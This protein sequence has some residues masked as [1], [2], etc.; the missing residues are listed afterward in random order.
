MTWI[1]E[2]HSKQS[3]SNFPARLQKHVPME[4][5]EHSKKDSYLYD[6]NS[7]IEEIIVCEQDESSE[8]NFISLNSQ[9]SNKMLEL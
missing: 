6:S 4:S 2:A 3:H 1:E 9:N 7:I 5:I 8:Y